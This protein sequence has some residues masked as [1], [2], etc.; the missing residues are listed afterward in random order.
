[1]LSTNMKN[2]KRDSN[3]ISRNDKHKQNTLDRIKGRLE[4]KTSEPDSIAIE[5]IQTKTEKKTKR[6]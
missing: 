4:L 5:T 3:Q 6:N 1:M 2:K